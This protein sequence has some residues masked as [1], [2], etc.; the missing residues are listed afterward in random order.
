M[1]K[2]PKEIVQMLKLIGKINSS[3]PLLEDSYEELEDCLNSGAWSW[4]PLRKRV[5]ASKINRCG[6]VLNGPIFTCEAYEW[7]MHKNLPMVPVIQLD[8]ARCSKVSGVDFGTGLLQVWYG[9]GNFMG[10]DA[11]IRVIPAEQVHKSKLL[12]VPL[13]DFEKM[14]DKWNPV[15][16]LDWAKD[17][18]GKTGFYPATQISRYN[19]RHFTLSSI[20]V[21]GKDHQLKQ[22][23]E[24]LKRIGS[25]NK[26]LSIKCLS[27]IIQ[28]DELIEYAIKH[29][30]AGTHLMGAFDYIQY[31]PR[32]KPTPLFC[33]GGSGDCYNFGDGNAQLF[34][35]K[36]DSGKIS[37]SFDWSCC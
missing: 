32:R 33:F 17:Y 7:P 27:M 13:F 20:Y 3:C 31:S 25:G 6:D 16:S 34:F 19:K 21:N 15:A 2:Y 23:I 5:R 10:K 30:G 37:F 11:F 35:E 9:H 4:S 28:L 8:L 12:P 22:Q 29:W 26:C 14:E 18:D 36:D 1:E 24:T